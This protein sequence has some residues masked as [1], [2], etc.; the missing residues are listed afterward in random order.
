MV[1]FAADIDGMA[2]ARWEIL[3]LNVKGCGGPPRL[4]NVLV[5]PDLRKS[6]FP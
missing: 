5:V 6:D 4:S 1:K 3:L 2:T